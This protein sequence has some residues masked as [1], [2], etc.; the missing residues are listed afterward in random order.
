MR[1]TSARVRRVMVMPGPSSTASGAA[2]VEGREARAGPR[3][4]ASDAR[5]AG[6]PP[7]FEDP[8]RLVAAG[9][10]VGRAPGRLA[11]DAATGRLVVRGAPGRLLLMGMRLQPPPERSGGETRERVGARVARRL[12]QLLLDAQQ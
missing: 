12:A 9:R 1:A 6:V 3:A 11:P 4:R 5:R 8:P 10:D 2:P 7:R